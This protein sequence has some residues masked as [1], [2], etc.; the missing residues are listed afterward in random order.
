VGV[1]QGGLLRACGVVTQ[2]VA[3][4]EDDII[5]GVRITRHGVYSRFPLA[6]VPV[7]I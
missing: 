2:V 4:D 5:A 6:D 1:A 3:S 7:R